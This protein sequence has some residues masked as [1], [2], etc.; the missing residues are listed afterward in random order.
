VAV[1][2]ALFVLGAASGKVAAQT[3]GGATT[4]KSNAEARAQRRAVA[5]NL[6]GHGGPVKAIHVDVASG[7]VVTGSFDYSMILWSRIEAET[8]ATALWRAT[9]LGGAVNAVGVVRDPTQLNISGPYIDQVVAA[10]DDGVVTLWQIGEPRPLH[11][12]EGHQGK[13]VALD[14][15]HH[16]LGPVNAVAFSQDGKRVFT[17]SADGQICVFDAKSG[18]LDRAIY[19]HGWGINVLQRIPGTDHLVIGALNGAVS[20]IDGNSGDVVRD[21]PAHERPVL[22]VA[23]VEKPGLIA[24]GGG[25]GVV[26]VMR[27]ADGAVVEEHKNTFGPV[28][29]LAFVTDGSALYYGG[30]DDF[31]T[32]WKF[33]PRAAFEDVDASQM[34]R[35]LLRSNWQTGSCS[36]RGSA[37]FVIR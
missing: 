28:W 33:A 4:P 25:D 16:N 18:Q 27:I 1:T 37:V 17:A 10:G 13:V 32:L 34:P 5:G 3:G 2:C 19:K 11:R 12:F 7:H 23:V 15:Y 30:L 31:V 22:A 24:T 21:L 20:I 6:V 9:E 8:T 29:A 35:R 26:R 36:S 14:V